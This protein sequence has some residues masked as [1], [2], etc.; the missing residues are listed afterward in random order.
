MGRVEH[1]PSKANLV[2]LAPVPFPLEDGLEV[3]EVLERDTNRSG[4]FLDRAAGWVSSSLL[5]F[6]DMGGVKATYMGD[7]ILG[8]PRADAKEPCRFPK[9][10]TRN[11]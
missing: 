9:R 6:G 3:V 2:L 8:H 10:G 4:E 1:R 5:E 11:F 7:F